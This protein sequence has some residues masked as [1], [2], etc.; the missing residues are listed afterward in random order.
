[1]VLP[2]VL[3]Q[4]CLRLGNTRRNRIVK[5]NTYEG[6]HCSHSGAL[7]E[8]GGQGTIKWNAPGGIPSPPKQTFFITGT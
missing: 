1:M 6:A 5:S 8:G 4:G 3:L 7:I 2:R